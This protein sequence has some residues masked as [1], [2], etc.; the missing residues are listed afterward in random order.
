[1]NVLPPCRTR[2]KGPVTLMMD[3]RVANVIP[4]VAAEESKFLSFNFPPAWICA[5]W[6]WVGL[7]A[8]YWIPLAVSLRSLVFEVCRGAF[9]VEDQLKVVDGL[10]KHGKAREK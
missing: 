10:G 5:S 7:F 8:C 1:M 6:A 9:G 4:K 2:G 3:N